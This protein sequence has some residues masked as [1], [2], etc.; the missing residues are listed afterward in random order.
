MRVDERTMNR[1]SLLRAGL[2]VLVV[3]V[4]SPFVAKA[5]QNE[6]DVCYWEQR[7]GSFCRDGT[8]YEYWCYVCCGGLECETMK[9]EWRA[10]GPC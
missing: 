7:D 9:C 1:R 5:E 2:S 8:H 4:V 3:A 10:V 6:A